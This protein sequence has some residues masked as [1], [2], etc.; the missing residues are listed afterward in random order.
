MK[1]LAGRAVLIAAA[2]LTMLGCAALPKTE[3]AGTA[4]GERTF[5]LAGAGVPAIVFEAGLGDGKDSWTR[6]FNELRDTSR[7]F[8]YDRAG[9]GGSPARDGARSGAQI[10]DELRALL[11]AAGVR[12]PYVLVGHSLGGTFVELYARLHPQEVAGVVL[13]ESRHESFAQRCKQIA[14]PICE[15]PATLVSLMP[16]AA[17]QEYHAANVTMDQVRSAGPF[18]NVP[19]VVLTGTR[20]LVEGP[21]FN[22]A[23][24]ETQQ[25]LVRLSPQGR[26]EVC[27][28]CGHYV[29]RD[30]PE[31]VVRAVR[32]VVRA[33][34]ASGRR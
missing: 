7:V 1:P 20:K 16:G 4:F 22:K 31:L 27:E 10:V 28:S 6:L 26:H 25:R 24:L 17:A 11:Q 9:Y 15:P 21:A 3:R 19:L 33:S 30:R 8:A 2:L 12:P 34:S 18:P 14:A 5:M 13:V 29:Q 32:E 23:W